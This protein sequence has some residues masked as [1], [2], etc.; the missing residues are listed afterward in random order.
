[1]I[2]QSLSRFL[3]ERSELRTFMTRLLWG[4]LA[5]AR[6]LWGGCLPVNLGGRGFVLTAQTMSLTRPFG[7]G[8]SI[9]R[10]SLALG[11]CTII[12]LGD[13]FDDASYGTEDSGCDA[14]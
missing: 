8:K 3:S 4:C 11:A 14:H 10:L 13:S 9:A 2:R 6:N 5:A 1:M 12:P 7:C